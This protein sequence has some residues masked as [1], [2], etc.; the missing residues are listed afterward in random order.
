LAQPWVA[1]R[2][3]LDLG[4]PNRAGLELLRSAG[5]DRIIVWEPNRALRRGL[6]QG[7]EPLEREELPL[8]VPAASV[9]VILCA[10]RL[11]RTD[12]AGRDALLREV[13][14][15]VVP[16]GVA[17]VIT[18][19]PGD[20][21]LDGPT[22]D[23]GAGIG[24]WELR[25][26]VSDHFRQVCIVG[27][28]P[29][30]GCYLTQLEPSV[31]EEARE[32]VLSD[33]LVSVSE[34]ASHFIAVLSPD[35]APRLEP[36]QLVTMPL[37]SLAEGS[38]P[39]AAAQVPAK[40][41]LDG[42]LR[43]LADARAAR[44]DL[45]RGAKQAE[46]AVT[47]LVLERDN[48]AAYQENLL[49]ERRELEQALAQT[50]EALELRRQ[51]SDR[52]VSLTEA[53]EQLQQVAASKDRRIQTLEEQLAGARGE[54]EQLDRRLGNQELELDVRVGE[55]AQA[56]ERIEELERADRE[57]QL[58]L[59]LR[60][61][62]RSRLTGELESER[63]RAV[64]LE[65]EV[66]EL[67]QA[68]SDWERQ[69][70]A[71]QDLM[72]DERYRAS[73][74]VG[75]L[76]DRGLELEQAERELA[77]AKRQMESKERSLAEAQWQ[78]E[79]AS[80]A[81]EGAEAPESSPPD[82]SADTMPSEAPQPAEEPSAEQARIRGGPEGEDDQPWP[83][84]GDTEEPVPETAGEAGAGERL[85]PEGAPEGAPEQS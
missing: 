43:E 54:L 21:A 37:R 14:R 56:T 69:L 39:E 83:E 65:R 3:V 49:R 60:D 73:K 6:P 7:V 8:Q 47:E 72:E 51:E 64:Q 20:R 4:R 58:L 63:A 38:A 70:Q 25:S 31:P 28:R 12:A 24:Y 22:G 1:G 16:R 61:D 33:Q 11:D 19:N 59:D 35:T 85:A 36:Y 76:K 15:V 67:Q 46:D 40:Q 10:D 68:R 79:R 82:K 77:W 23:P 45:V 71:Q 75:R 2:V 80:K 48:L 34:E 26:T 41:G 55:L 13:R 18:R 81:G 44:D 32:L 66:A 50:Q 9:D 52:L 57:R 29:M 78:L 30:A 74:L 42:L 17:V 84:W 62:E 53:L 27:Q 5:A